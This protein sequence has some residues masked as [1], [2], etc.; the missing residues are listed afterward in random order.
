MKLPKP[1]I[2]SYLLFGVLAALAL[3]WVAVTAHTWNLERSLKV[4]A[5]AKV[6]DLNAHFDTNF[7]QGDFDLVPRVTAYQ[8]YL[9]F[10]PTHGKIHILMRGTSKKGALRYGAF[11][12]FLVHNGER[13]VEK[14]SGFCNDMEM[15]SEAK[16]Y[17]A[18]ME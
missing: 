6:V 1:G 12:Y 17:F 16:A 18:S 2:R 5:D 15:A 11:D 13:W 10:G 9:L 4:V 8:E 14:E 3:L 7:T